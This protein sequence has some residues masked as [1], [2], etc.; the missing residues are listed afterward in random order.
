MTRWAWPEQEECVTISI[1]VQWVIW[2]HWT[3]HFSLNTFNTVE[4][5]VVGALNTYYPTTGFSAA[6][7]LA[8]E[9]GEKYSLFIHLSYWT[10][11]LQCS[12]HLLG[13]SLGMRHDGIRDE[14]NSQSFI[15][16]RSRDRHGQTQWSSCSD[17]ALK[18][19]DR[20]EKSHKSHW[21]VKMDDSSDVTLYSSAQR[22]V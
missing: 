7:T 1:L 3:S 18:K 16:S 15:M 21:I 8:H 20:Y 17:Q 14:C 12:F 4:F 10:S 5:G 11:T 13:H 19:N 2:Q 6:Y 22:R 9:I